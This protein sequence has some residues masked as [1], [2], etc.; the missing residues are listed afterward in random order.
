MVH[1]TIHRRTAWIARRLDGWS[2]PIVAKRSIIDRRDR[3]ARKARCHSFGNPETDHDSDD[4]PRFPTISVVDVQEHAREDEDREDEGDL[5]P[6]SLHGSRSDHGRG[7]T[8]SSPGLENPSSRPVL[9]PRGDPAWPG[10]GGAA[11]PSV[12]GIDPHLDFSL[13]IA[14]TPADSSRIQAARCGSPIHCI[15]R[16]RR[17]G[18]ATAGRLVARDGLDLLD[19]QRHKVVGRRDVSSWY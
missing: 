3:R 15:K 6:G 4:D 8:H 16:R 7:N 12:A 10:A 17:A 9:A 14:V 11:D 18:G 2:G 13:E 1:E 5:Q 19:D